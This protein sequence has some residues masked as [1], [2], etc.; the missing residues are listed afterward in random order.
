MPD[1]VANMERLLGQLSSENGDPSM[2]AIQAIERAPGK[3]RKQVAGVQAV[4]RADL[5]SSRWQHRLAC[6]VSKH[7]G[8]GGRGAALT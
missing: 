5:G 1:K 4:A 3:L 6:G 8:F 2:A 7:G